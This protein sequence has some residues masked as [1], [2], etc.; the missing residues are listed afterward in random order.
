[1]AR[2]RSFDRDRALEQ[3]TIAFWENGYEQTSISDLTRAMG[4]APPSLY[5]AFGD[6]RRLFDEV[7]ARYQVGPGMIVASGVQEPTARGAIERMLAEAARQY[8]RTDLPQG[9]MV[10][11]EPSLVAERAVTREAIRARIQRGADAGELPAATDV[12]ALATYVAVVLAGMS[13]HARDGA[14]REQLTAIAETAMR[15]WP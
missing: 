11:S 5:A 3:A 14:T 8:A 4:I 12:D 1:M 9:C 13:A 2:P 15:A 7:V 6:K 10:V